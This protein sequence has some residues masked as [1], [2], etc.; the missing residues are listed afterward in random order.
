[1]GLYSDVFVEHK[2]FL[3]V[4]LEPR[5]IEEL[6]TGLDFGVSVREI[7]KDLKNIFYSSSENMETLLK[8]KASSFLK[9]EVLKKTLSWISELRKKGGSFLIPPDPFLRTLEELK[10]RLPNS[11]KIKHYQLT[12]SQSVSEVLIGNSEGFLGTLRKRYFRAVVVVVAED[13]G[14][15]ERGYEVRAYPLSLEEVLEQ[16]P[17]FFSVAER[18]GNLALIML[19]AKRAPAGVMPVVLSGEAGGTMIHEAVGH[20]LEAD[21]AEEGLSVY[22]GRLGEQV[23]SPLITVI[24]DPTLPN[25]YGSYEIDD[26]GT[27]AKRTIL[28]ER[29]ILKDF[30]YDRY[31]ALKF[32]REPNGH[33]RRE[34]F[35]HLPIPRMSNTFIAPG[36]HKAEDIIKS[37]DRGLLVRKMGGGEVNPLT[38]DFV[39]EVREGYYIENGEVAYPVKGAT[40]VGNG[41]KV[42]EIIDMVANDL[43]FDPGTCGKDGQ[44]VPVS[45]GQPTLRIPEITVG[46]TL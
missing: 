29:G 30:L 17:E 20:G 12:L 26:E 39:F 44:G 42:L 19:S 9:E 13:N 2:S 8:E 16:D 24:D 41:P 40:L 21:H 31:S 36:P 23:A 28:I 11:P 7:T 6:S 10:K 34:S 4:R 46:G 18:A 14:K 3:R 37:I 33:G 22:S 25:L 35:R 27:P 5:G 15:L 38:G 32:G 43:H 45:D 1:M